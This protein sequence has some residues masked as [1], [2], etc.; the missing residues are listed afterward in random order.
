[1]AYQRAYLIIDNETNELLDFYYDYG[2]PSYTLRVA[3]AAIKE[4]YPND[5]IVRGVCIHTPDYISRWACG[6]TFA[7]AE[8][9]FRNGA[10]D[11]WR[12]F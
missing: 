5:R 10:K 8:K 7:E 12:D 1:M 4:R 3:K 6:K 2:N 9:N 11:N